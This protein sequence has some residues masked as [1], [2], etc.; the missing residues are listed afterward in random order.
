M[1][2]IDAMRGLDS[3]LVVITTYS[4][5]KE[6]VLTV[7]DIGVGISE[8]ELGQI[9]EPF[10]TTKKNSD[11]LGLGLSICAGIVQSFSGKIQVTNRPDGGAQF[12]VIL[13]LSDHNE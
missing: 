11:S 2:A 9:F 5:G 13:P 10:F 4:Q 8:Q 12:E 7:Q 3:C 1:N 6:A